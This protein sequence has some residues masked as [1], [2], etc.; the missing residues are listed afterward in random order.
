MKSKPEKRMTAEDLMAKL[1][2]DPEFVRKN[3]ERDAARLALEERLTAEEKPLLADLAD[4]G[5][6]V[7][8]VY[9]LVNARWSYPSAIP[10][11]IKHLRFPYDHRIREGIA[12]ALTVKESRGNSAREILEQLKREPEKQIGRNFRGTL[13][14][15]K[16]SNNRC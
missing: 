10:V 16:R 3:E 2:I 5:I 14:F 6:Q 8:S 12:R 9:D 1:Q 7:R 11:L 4:S 15:G 13:D